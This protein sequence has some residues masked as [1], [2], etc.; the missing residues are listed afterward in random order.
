MTKHKK[1]EKQVEETEEVKTPVVRDVTEP[2]ESAKEDKAEVEVA[3]PVVTKHIEEVETK[4][5]EVTEVLTGHAKELAELAN[6]SALVM[7]TLMFPVG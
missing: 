6:D 7:K 3:E 1:V 4:H 2:T 5:V